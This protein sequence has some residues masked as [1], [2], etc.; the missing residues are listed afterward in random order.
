GVFTDGRCGGTKHIATLPP[1]RTMGLNTQ[2]EPFAA[3]MDKDFLLSRI[4]L[5]MRQKSDNFGVYPVTN[6]LKS[7]IGV[8]LDKATRCCG[9]NERKENSRCGT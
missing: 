7:E 3:P 8:N 6:E 4:V 2:F 9:R 1:Q 5:D